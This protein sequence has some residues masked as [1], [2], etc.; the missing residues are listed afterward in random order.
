[1]DARI[2]STMRQLGF[3]ANEA[4]AYMALLRQH[5]ATGYELAAA[6]GI[7]RSAIYT[8]LRGLEAQ[9]LV[10][11]VSP[12]PARYVPLPPE[13][14]IEVLSSRFSRSLEDLGDSRR[15]LAAERPESTTWTLRGYEGLL[16]Q[17]RSLIEGA[18]TSVHASIWRREV[19]RLAT[20]LREAVARGVEVVLFSFT[21]LPDDLGTALGYG[22]DEAA[23]GQHWTHGLILI[24][25][26]AQVILG[27]A[28][29]SPSNRAV[30]TNEDAIVSMARSN[31][32]LD[33]T[34]FGQ[35]TGTPTGEIV[36]HLTAHLAPVEDLLSAATKPR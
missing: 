31:L 29:E 16:D 6:S 20:P 11:A 12:S 27:G 24:A 4:R 32:V 30:F 8:V 36:S 21:A 25:D 5:P 33:I 35:R 18:T 28:E 19:D 7:P 22:I 3:T 10:N 9:G 14:L 26:G 13:R 1:V 23:L 34:L 17:A 2:E 15:R